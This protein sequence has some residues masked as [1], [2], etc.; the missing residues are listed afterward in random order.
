M[1]GKEEELQ[2]KVIFR[3]KQLTGSVKAAIIPSSVS[4][5][6]VLELSEVIFNCPK[7]LVCPHLFLQS[8]G[9]ALHTL[10]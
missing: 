7:F 9:Y 10:C 8:S 4:T 5:L 6:R 3:H 2:E 1:E